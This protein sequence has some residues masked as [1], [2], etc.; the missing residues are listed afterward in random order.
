MTSSVFILGPPGAGKTSISRL[1]VDKLKWA[2]KTIDQWT[3]GRR[4]LSD[5]EVDASLARLF[6]NLNVDNELVEFAHHDYLALFAN[7][8][9]AHLR[10]KR[11]VLLFAPLDVC[12]ERN[13]ARLS[14]VARKYVERSWRSSEAFLREGSDLGGLCIIQT[15]SMSVDDATARMIKWINDD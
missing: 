5:A 8:A 6:A 1:A 12:L 10:A 2:H 14:P 4:E 7:P 13:S 9:N 15:E 3:P 11:K